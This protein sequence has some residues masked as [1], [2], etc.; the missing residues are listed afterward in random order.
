MKTTAEM[1]KEERIEKFG[2]DPLDRLPYIGTSSP[3]VY[4]GEKH[5]FEFFYNAE[6]RRIDVCY[7]G[8][9]GTHCSG[10]EIADDM[11]DLPPALNQAF[12]EVKNRVPKV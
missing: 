1:S 10:S 2:F 3:V 11:T 8:C 12:F 5:K 6:T 7:A 9:N 4:R